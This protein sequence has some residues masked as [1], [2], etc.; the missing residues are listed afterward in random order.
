MSFQRSGTA[1]VDHCSNKFTLFYFHAPHEKT[2]DHGGVP[3]GVKIDRLQYA[4]DFVRIPNS[5]TM[6]HDVF[7]QLGRSSW[8]AFWDGEKLWPKNLRFVHIFYLKNGGFAGK[9]DEPQ[10]RKFRFRWNIFFNP[11]L[12]EMIPNLRNPFLR[13]VGST[14]NCWKIQVPL[15]FMFFLITEKKINFWKKEIP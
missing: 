2:T 8:F 12:A 13:C 14:T 5:T 1:D 11:K 9:G 6:I 4:C 3:C 10:L 15:K 7:H